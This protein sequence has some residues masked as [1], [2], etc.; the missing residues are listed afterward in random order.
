[1][2]GYPDENDLLA[3][4][5]CEPILLDSTEKDVPLFYNEATFQISNQEEDFI[6]I[7]SPSHRKVK[8]QVTHRASAEVTTLLDLKRV[9]HFEIV[10]DN[11]NRSR[12][13]LRSVDDDF[14]QTIEID[15]KPRF[16]L[17]VKEHSIN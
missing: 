5:E 11:R 14:T 2:Q 9:D 7:I 6:V 8:I 3:L 17:I 10:A 15:F 12:V 16:K 4:F 1:M 13:L